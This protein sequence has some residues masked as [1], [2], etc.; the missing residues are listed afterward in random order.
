MSHDGTLVYSLLVLKN[1]IISQKNSANGM[2]HILCRANVCGTLNLIE[3][4]KF[5]DVDL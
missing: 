5:I 3:Y 1:H 2:T 4:F